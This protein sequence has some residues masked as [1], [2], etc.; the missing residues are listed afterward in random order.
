MLQRVWAVMVGGGKGWRAWLRAIAAA[1]ATA[2]AIAGCG[3]SSGHAQNPDARDS[4]ATLIRGGTKRM[5]KGSA[6][7]AARLFREA[8]DKQP[9]NP[10]AYYDLGVAQ[11]AQGLRKSSLA[12]YAHA[13]ENDP[14]YVPALYNLGVAFMQTDPQTAMYYFSRV[15]QLKHDSPTAYFN[16]GL[17]EL[18]QK[19]LRAR[20]LRALAAAVKLDPSLRAQV[21]APLRSQ[22][23]ADG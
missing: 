12:D 18:S 9:Q 8:I 5:Q 3:G 1:M 13:I 20:G 21:P 4:Y 22:L 15:L 6:S 14:R 7:A 2:L 19:R 17:L 11:S 10:I 23:P 16:L